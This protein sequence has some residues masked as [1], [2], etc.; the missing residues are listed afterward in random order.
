[1][2]YTLL[3]NSG[4]RV[5][6]VALGTMTFGS[7]WGWGA[8]Q[9]ESTKQFDVFAEA[10]GTLIDTAN[11]YTDGSA[12]TILGDLLAADRDHF[13]VGTKY[14]LNTRTGDLNAGATTARTSRPRSTRHSAGCA[15]TAWTS[16][17][18][19]PGTT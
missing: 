7:D 12:E 11:K 17:G 1:M 16:S 14:S 15:P 4:L 19:T 10:G 5:S 6:E 2:R 3:G 9:S 18:S 8:D 13:V